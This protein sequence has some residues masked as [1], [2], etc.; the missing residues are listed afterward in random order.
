MIP[1]NTKTNKIYLSKPSSKFQIPYLS[2][3]P[4]EWLTPINST[5]DDL[6]YNIISIKF[7]EKK[8][9]TR[10]TSSA[11]L[12]TA[13]ILTDRNLNTLNNFMTFQ[14]QFHLE[15][16]DRKA[17]INE[18][19]R[20]TL[21]YDHHVPWKYIDI[22]IDESNNSFK[23]AKKNLSITP[24][25]SSAPSDHISSTPET[26]L[27]HN[28]H[29]GKTHDDTQTPPNATNLTQTP[30]SAINLT[31]ISNLVLDNQIN[32]INNKEITPTEEPDSDSNSHSTNQPITN[33]ADEVQ[34]LYNS[35]IQSDSD[36]AP[37]NENI[38]NNDIRN[39]ILINEQ[40]K[41]IE[42]CNKLDT[43]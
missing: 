8:G 36:S 3:A 34:H 26:N 22:Q 29:L 17:V 9:V 15:K 39:T 1:L 19:L 16:D 32:S 28:N 25:K 14:S 10:S 43:S 24:S 7:E 4:T 31:Q 30:S 27:N 5:N 41:I 21:N 11:S 12:V 13:N 20:N 23:T 35:E 42:W 18:V 6:T 37:N 38:S 33:W 2:N 40:E